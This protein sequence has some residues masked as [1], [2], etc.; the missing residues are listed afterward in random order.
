MPDLAF[1]VHINRDFKELRFKIQSSSKFKSDKIFVVKESA[2]R[3]KNCYHFPTLATLKL[4]TLQ[5]DNRFSDFQNTGFM[6]AIFAIPTSANV[7]RAA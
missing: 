7:I 6:L 2:I 5:I 3:Y 4:L 1:L